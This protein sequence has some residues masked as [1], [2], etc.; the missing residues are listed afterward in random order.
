MKK[1]KLRYYLVI[2][3]IGSIVVS[4]SKSNIEDNPN[5]QV[6]SETIQIDEI[7]Q[8]ISNLEQDYESKFGV[9][10]AFDYEFISNDEFLSRMQEKPGSAANITTT[11]EDN[12]VEEQ[13]VDVL[14]FPKYYSDFRWKSS[15]DLHQVYNVQNLSIVDLADQLENIVF[16]EIKHNRGH[17]WRLRR[18]QLATVLDFYTYWPVQEKWFRLVGARVAHLNEDHSSIDTNYRSSNFVGP[19]EYDYAYFSAFM[20][21]NGIYQATDWE[22]GE[23]NYVGFENIPRGNQIKVFISIYYSQFWGSRRTTDIEYSTISYPN[24]WNQIHANEIGKDGKFLLFSI[25]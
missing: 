15:A 19:N 4:C 2:F 21:N 23:P 8:F 1:M 11:T 12:F 10:I 18:N 24:G 3:L 25:D 6:E 13:A 20:L 22:E 5:L 9:A 7:D 14:K 17:R 16:T